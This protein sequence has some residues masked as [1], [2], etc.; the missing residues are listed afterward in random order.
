MNIEELNEKLSND[1]NVILING[2][3]GIGKTYYIKNY[4]KK[5]NYIYISLFGINSL[6]ELEDTL[7]LELSLKNEK[8]AKTSHFYENRSIISEAFKND[9]NDAL[10]SDLEI[11]IDDID[12]KSS[13]I[14]YKDLFGVI[15]S[16]S[17]IINIKIIL[18]AN[19]KNIKEIEEF[20]NYSEKVIDN[21]YKIKHCSHEAINNITSYNL[22]NNK[23]DGILTEE[24]F[25]NYVTNFLEKYKIKNLRNISRMVSF[26]LK[27]LNLLEIS[28][29]SKG[30]INT[31][32]NICFAIAIEKS[33]NVEVDNEYVTKEIVSN[34]LTDIIYPL[35]R[36][37]LVSYIISIYEEDN[38]ENN[39]IKINE[40][41]KEVRSCNSEEKEKDLFYCSNEKIEKRIKKFI[42]TSILKYN[43][44]LSIDTWY[45]KLYDLYFYAELIGRK[46]LFIDEDIVKIMNSYIENIKCNEISL[47]NLILKM[48]HETNKTDECLNLY[49]VLKDKIIYKYFI[50]HYEASLESFEKG[51]YDKKAI[52]NLITF[53]LGTEF[54]NINDFDEALSI[55]RNKNLF[56]P[57]LDGEIDTTVWEYVHEIWKGITSS[58]DSQNRRKLLN[59]LIQISND[60]YQTATSIGKHRI[61]ILNEYYNILQM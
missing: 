41:Y 4:L 36:E 49:R 42:K 2:V 43:N 26:S 12:K 30:D 16:L 32:T 60:M 5:K 9:L 3:T 59:L 48:Q 1:Y 56:I 25:N 47:F 10:S 33:N 6:K 8:I 29:L 13:L 40:F 51:T 34:Y 31:I 15:E 61:S 14:D 28:E 37:D 27:V 55:L 17:K 44:R 39:I 57:S 58:D 23:L 21:I 11:V 19:T 46:D 24:K 7:L 53:I 45:N 18:I 22:K 38:I 54:K 35:S 20:S 50:Y 52:A